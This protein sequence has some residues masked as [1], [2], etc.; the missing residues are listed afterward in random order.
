[1]CSPDPRFLLS[2]YGDLLAAKEG[3]VSASLVL[4]RWCVANSGLG[5]SVT[6]WGGVCLS[7]Q[8]HLTVGGK[9]VVCGAECKHLCACAVWCVCW[10]QEKIQ[11]ERK[12]EEKA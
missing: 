4:E 2:Y 9:H 11:L 10:R 8:L 6:P 5:L 7:L 3:R 1:M 12:L